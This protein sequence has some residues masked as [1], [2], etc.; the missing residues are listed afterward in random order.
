MNT[1]LT[2]EMAMD[3]LLSVE[4]T[5]FAKT[6][7]ISLA[8]SWE[9]SATREDDGASWRSTGEYSTDCSILFAVSQPLCNKLE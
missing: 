5:L 9:S 8:A 3:R 4:T 7:C 6:L 1:S 2:I